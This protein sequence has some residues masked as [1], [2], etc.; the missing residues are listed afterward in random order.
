MLYTNKI[1]ETGFSFLEIETNTSLKDE[2]QAYFAGYAEGLATH[3]I[4]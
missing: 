1:N 2:N 4:I 3:E